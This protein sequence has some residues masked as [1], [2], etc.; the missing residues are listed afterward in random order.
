MARV[1]I[2]G[3]TDADSRDTGRGTRCTERAPS[4]G[5]TADLT[6]VSMC[7]TSSTE[8]AC[9]RGLTVEAMP[10]SGGTDGST[11][12]ACPPRVTVRSST[13]NTRTGSRS[14]RK[15]D[16]SFEVDVRLPRL[17]QREFSVCATGWTDTLS[18]EPRSV[19]LRAKPLQSF[20]EI[21]VECLLSLTVDCKSYLHEFACSLSACS[22]E[23]ARVKHQCCH[24]A[25]VQ[26]SNA[27]M[28]WQLW[29]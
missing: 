3:M 13:W 8:R 20:A 16:G 7:A 10:G 28:C 1:S 21:D 24:Q 17:P 25:L 5:R 15:Y 9:S 26:R 2:V 22:F 29:K 6:R 27:G 12:R 4:P 18:V 23:Q 11:A 14:F 19:T